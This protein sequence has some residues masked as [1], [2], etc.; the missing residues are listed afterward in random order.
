MN[1]IVPQNEESKRLY[2]YKIILKELLKNYGL[3]ITGNKVEFIARLDVNYPD[4]SWLEEDSAPNRDQIEVE[5]QP[6]VNTPRNNA[7][8]GQSV[9]QMSEIEVMRREMNFIRRER[10]LLQRE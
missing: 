1:D 6:L 4:G 7:S 10:D 5:T 2:G 8:D 9:A 3:P